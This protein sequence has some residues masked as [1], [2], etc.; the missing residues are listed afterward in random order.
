[1]QLLSL[2]LLA[3]S[4]FAVGLRDGLP[5]E[6]ITFSSGALAD[7][8]QWLA[9]GEE[10]TTEALAEAQRWLAQAEDASYKAQPMQV[11]ASNEATWDKDEFEVTTIDA[12]PE[13]SLRVK[14][15]Q[16]LCDTTVKQRSGYLDISDSRHLFFVR[17][18]RC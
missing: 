13:H 7:A 17:G 8:R 2:T 14:E 11:L 12:L 6:Q 3:T 9:H 4:A 18:T 16:G 5:G 15:P 10:A 1:M